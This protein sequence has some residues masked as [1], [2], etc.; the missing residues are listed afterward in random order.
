MPKTNW[1]ARRGQH[2]TEL[3]IVFAVIIAVLGALRVY[4]QRGLQARQKA[5]VGYL[6]SE[7][8]KTAASQGVANLQ[9][10]KTQYDPYY[11][12]MNM[13]ESWSDNST[14]GFPDKSIERNSSRSGWQQVNSA[15]DAD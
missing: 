13:T 3:A 15:Q 10:T 5:G 2:A 8:N 7:I 1:S 11:R 6:F 14:N 4:V 12:E 9:N